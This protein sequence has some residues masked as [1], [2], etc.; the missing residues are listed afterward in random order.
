MPDFKSTDLLNAIRNG[1]S[2][3]YIARVPL[4]TRENIAQVGTAILDQSYTRNEFVSSLLNKIGLSVVKGA[5]FENPLKEFKKG[6][7]EWGKH[8][9]EIYVDIITANAFDP[10]LA[11]T[12]LFKKNMPKISAIFHEQNRRDQYKTTVSIPQLKT[13]FMSDN[14]FTAL[15]DKVV[16][17]LYTSD[18]Q[19]EFLLMKNLIHQ[20]GVEG[21]FKMISVAPVVDVATA[22]LAM[23]K[24][25]ETSNDLTFLKTTFN[26]AGV[27]T[28]TPKNDQIILINTHFD[29]LIDVELLATAFN[30]DKA[31]FATRRVLVDDFGG[32]DN[33]LCAIVDKDWFMVYESFMSSEE[34]YNPQGLY[35]NYFLNHWQ[36]MSTSQF[37][38]AV[39]IVTVAPTITS[40]VLTP[41]T[42]TVAKGG[43]L[44]LSV[45]AVGTGNPPSKVVYTHDGEDSYIS[46]TGLLIVGMGETTG[47]LTVTATSVFDPTKTDTCAVTVA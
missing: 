25:K 27:H 17:V 13:A 38:N 37:A 43:S 8:I 18:N 7:L 46:T 44:Q 19:D 3:E 12:E 2:P 41:A 10:K 23:T 21:K 15:I 14:G 29:A 26:H 40:I 20:Y 6:T 42:A 16:S 9:E 5:M 1:A 32:L 47:L 31:D 30:M 35:Y 39:L 45:E 34:I 33:V 24:I 4:A 22:K 36:V 28:S 11:E